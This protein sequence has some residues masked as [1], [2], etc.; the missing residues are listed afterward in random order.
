MNIFLKI[1]FLFQDMKAGLRL[2]FLSL[3]ELFNV[4]DVIFSSP[5]IFSFPVIYV[6]FNTIFV[7]VL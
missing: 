5:E 3:L 6:Y 4:Y 2:S 7:M 1:V